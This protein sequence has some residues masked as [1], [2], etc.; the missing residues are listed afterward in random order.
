MAASPRATTIIDEVHFLS[1]SRGYAHPFSFPHFVFSG[2]GTI[3]PGHHEL[4]MAQAPRLQ[5][6]KEVEAER[7]ERQFEFASFRQ[8][9][10]IFPTARTAW[11]KNKDC[12]NNCSAANI[13]K[14]LAE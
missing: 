1:L 11:K 8:E 10:H 4:V 3:P 14:N 7:R 2:L 6:S 13:D 9:S 5:T 12:P